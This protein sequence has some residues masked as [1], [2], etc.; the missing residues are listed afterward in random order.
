EQCKR[1]KEAEAALKK[2]EEEARLKSESE[3]KRRVAEETQRK[4][5]AENLRKSQPIAENKVVPR[6]Q[7][8][9]RKANARPHSDELADYAAAI[10]LAWE[11]GIPDGEQAGKLEKLREILAVTAEEHDRLDQSAKREAYVKAFKALWGSRE[12]AQGPATI[13]TL[14]KKFGITPEEAEQLD[15]ELL[16]RIRSPKARPQLVVIDDD[17]S[18]LSSMAD[19]LCDRGFDVRAFTTS[20]EAYEFLLQSTPDLILADINLESSTM[21]GFAF[22][23][24]IQ[25][26]PRLSVVPFI[27]V[28]GLTDEVVIR[29]GKELGA[30]DYITKPFVGETL[31][32]IIKGKLRRYSE[33]L[34]L[35]EN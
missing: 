32:A 25:H 27:F 26:I 14:H 10:G 31:V 28:S 13:T 11:N 18:L 16:S 12:S 24:K 35:R 20:D 3:R 2:A 8:R 22:F 29:A 34:A 21:G 17:E 6:L 4:L 19:M 5:E 1:N 15:L 33:L 7:H 30:D 9:E 23:E